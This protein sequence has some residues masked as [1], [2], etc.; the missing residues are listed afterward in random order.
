MEAAEMIICTGLVDDETE[1]AEEYR[2]LLAAAVDRGLP[3]ICANPDVMVNRGGKTI[4]G[5]GAVAA[6]YEELGGMVQRFGKPYPEI[7]ERVFAESPEIPR[8][9]AVMIGDNLATDI[10]GARQ[11]GI[12]AIWI[13]GGIHAS[14]LALGPEGQLDQDTV[15]DVA[16]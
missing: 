16:G 4:Y 14:D 15:H 7:F 11:A 12:D 13:G 5:A 6:L 1:Q 8:S 10:R 3:M 2:S 9:R